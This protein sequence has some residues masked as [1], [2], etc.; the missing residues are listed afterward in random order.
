MSRELLERYRATLRDAYNMKDSFRG[1]G[2]RTKDNFAAL[3]KIS[4]SSP[5][6]F[7]AEAMET[8][9][10]IT[11]RVVLVTLKR[12][13]PEIASRTYAKF[14]RVVQ[15]QHVLS[16]IGHLTAARL[17]KQG[18]LDA[19]RETFDTLLNQALDE[20]M[21]REGD[22]EKVAA[23]E[24]TDAEYERR[25]N[26]RLRNVYNNTVAKF[27]LMKFRQ[28][29]KSM[30]RDRYCD[31]YDEQ[32][33]SLEGSLFGNMEAINTG[34]VPEYIK[35]LTVMSDM[36]RL[37]AD[38]PHALVD[39]FE[40]TLTELGTLPVLL[41][42]T[43]AAYNKYRAYCRHLGQMPL[44]NTDGAFLQALRDSS[45]YLRAAHRTKS[46]DVETIAMDLQALHRGGVPRLR[47]KFIS[48][49]F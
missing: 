11:E 14:Q 34:T 8:E 39:G 31:Y 25:S 33:A 1:G 4:L 15:N 28:I 21:L 29:V 16:V 49:E 5:I 40:F 18:S 38:N 17:V 44:Y 43:R 32:F 30:L 42:A 46:M 12:Q 36:S 13:A 2:S 41:L 23:G 37:P 45:Q 48:L 24:M 20:H 35:V 22:A 10:A 47:G 6:I 19:L 26:N 7:L 27:G 9:T 3:N